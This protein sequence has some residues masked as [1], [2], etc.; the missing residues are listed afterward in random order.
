MPGLRD[1]KE[2][3]YFYEKYVKYEIK[4]SQLRDEPGIVLAIEPGVGKTFMVLSVL[5]DEKNGALVIAPNPVVQIWGEQQGRFFTGDKVKLLT[6]SSLEK[7]QGL[8]SSTEPIKVVNVDFLQDSTHGRLEALNKNPRQVLVLDEGHFIGN[9]DSNQ[10]R[11]ASEIKGS[12]KILM[13]A[14]P[15]SSIDNIRAV[16]NFIEGGRPGFASRN[17]FG[18]SFN[19]SDPDSLRR[20][21]FMFNQYVIRIKKKNILDTYSQN[22]KEFKTQKDR[23]PLQLPEVE[24]PFEIS[25]HQA[26]EDLRIFTQWPQWQ[27][28]HDALGR[29]TKK[30]KQLKGSHSIKKP[31]ENMFSKKHATMQNHN[32]PRYTGSSED[33]PKWMAMDELLKKEMDWTK[34][35]G[36]IFVQY[37]EEA[38][39]YYERYGK[40]YG[41]VTF[42]GET[43]DDMPTKRGFLADKEGNI[44]R[45]M[46]K[47][48]YEYAIQNGN[49]V[50]YSQGKPITPLDYNRLM[51]QNNP[52]TRLMILTYDTGGQGQTLTAADFVVKDD[53]PDSHTKEFQAKE[54][55]NRIDNDNRKM[56][57]RSYSLISKYHPVFL[58]QM[59]KIFEVKN[60][61]SGKRQ[62]LT[63]DQITD[64]MWKNKDLTIRSYYEIYF[65]QGTYSQVQ[66]RR[67]RAQERF[68]DLILDGR[69]VPKGIDMADQ[70]GLKSAMP[71]LFET[72]SAPPTVTVRKRARNAAMKTI[73]SARG[74][75]DFTARQTPLEI[76]NSGEGINF[77]IDPAMLQ[78]WQNAPGAVGVIINAQPMTDLK[79]FLGIPNEVS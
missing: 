26:K 29:L 52:D 25:A 53:L 20:L 2:L 9:F 4:Q 11:Q 46:M 41:A 71:F 16:M 48:H 36:L 47:N 30:D 45:F 32:D 28:D 70:M 43:A 31:G 69:P 44:R 39:A 63:V 17:I 33:S 10:S 73:N 3:A 55:I 54:R 79:A 19:P 68:F 35:K 66:S 18:K 58:E 50:E 7:V 8:L 74:G 57:Q 72:I 5:Q 51:F 1:D 34:N 6:G 77:K 12:F 67:L 65:K 40:K 76:Q 37:V 59:M 13:S 75:I 21:H 15:F 14:T 64:Q 56:N 38:K 61:I 27:T 22:E 42:Y 23:L 24:V 60:K 78:E 49:L 62:R